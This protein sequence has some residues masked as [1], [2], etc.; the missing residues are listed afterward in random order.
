L[1]PNLDPDSQPVD[2]V[3]KKKPP[4]FE[5]RKKRR[6][7]SRINVNEPPCLQT[8]NSQRKSGFLGAFAPRKGGMKPEL[9]LAISNKVAWTSVVCWGKVTIRDEKKRYGNYEV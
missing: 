7:R 8:A 4:R 2:R 3:M 1:L 9:E 5:S 6:P